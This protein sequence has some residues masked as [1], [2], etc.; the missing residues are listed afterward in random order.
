MMA[1]VHKIQR[2]RSGLWRMRMI[3]RTK[4]RKAA[5]KCGGREFV[6]QIIAAEELER[7][8]DDAEEGLFGVAGEDFGE[9]T[10]MK[11]RDGAKLPI[12]LM[13]P[14]GGEENGGGEEC[15]RGLRA[16]AARAGGARRRSRARKVRE[17]RSNG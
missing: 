1:Q 12:D 14:D 7:E 4:T 13:A 6:A 15:E 2:R 16:I 5:R 17:R 9:I 3:G 11:R 8:D 10:G